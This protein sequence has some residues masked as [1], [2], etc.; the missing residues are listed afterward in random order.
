[1]FFFVSNENLELCDPFNFEFIFTLITHTH[2]HAYTHTRIHTHTYIQTLIHTYTYRHTAIHTLFIHTLIPCTYSYT[3]RHT[4]IVIH[5]QTHT[6]THRHI[7]IHRVSLCKKILYFFHLS[8]KAKPKPVLKMS[9]DKL[10][11]SLSDNV[12]WQ[13]WMAK[14]FKRVGKIAIGSITKRLRKILLND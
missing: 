12:N 3:Y 11:M 6:R 9:T 10:F 13:L 14:G 8:L 5:I 1:M 2:I 4:R 7:H